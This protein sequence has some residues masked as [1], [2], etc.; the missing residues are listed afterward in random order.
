[1]VHAVTTPDK[2]EALVQVTGELLHAQTTRID[3]V[4]LER[5][6][7]QLTVSYVRA[8]ERPFATMER[9]VEELWASGSVTPLSETM[10]LID[11]IRAEEVRDVFVRM[12]A[13]P[14]ALSITGKGV[15]VKSARHLAGC[16]AASVLQK[17]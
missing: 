16:L 11:D 6:K 3:P 1:M 9:A 5:A 13:H 17:P 14:P 15:S 10:A 2:I 8:S 4:H 12:L 7:N